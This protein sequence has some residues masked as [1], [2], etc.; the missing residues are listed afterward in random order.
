MALVTT[1]EMFEKAFQGGYA[2]GAFNINNMEIVQGVVAAAK[3]QMKY[4]NKIGAKYSVIIGDSE[5]E[6]N[7]VELKEMETGEKETVVLSELAE[8]LKAKLK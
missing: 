5:L 8:V 4:A 3:A 7:S 2:I 1:K 6:N